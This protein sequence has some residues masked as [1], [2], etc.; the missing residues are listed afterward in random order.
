[1]RS[2]PLDNNFTLRPLTAMKKIIPVL[3]GVLLVSH[4]VRAAILLNEIHLNPPGASGLGDRNYEYIE[5][6]STLTATDKSEPTTGITLLI[7]NNDRWDYKTNEFN[8]EVATKLNMGEVTDAW[9][10]DD[11]KTGTNGLLLLGDKYA[12][13]PKGGPWAGFIDPATEVGDPP[14]MGDGN[15]RSNDG[16]TIYLVAGW[17]NPV[18][19]GGTVLEAVVDFDVDDNGVLDWDQPDPKPAGSIPRPWLTTLDRI[20]T[21]DRNTTAWPTAP[22]PPGV[23]GIAEP[24]VA[25]AAANINVYALTTPP[26]WSMGDRDPDS[27]SRNA[28]NTTASLAAAWYG[29]KFPD[30]LPGT[31]P[32]TSIAFRENRVFGLAS[33]VATPGRVNL[34]TAPPVA[35][36]RINEVNLDPSGD[37]FQ[38]VEIVNTNSPS[39]SRSLSGY[40][41][42]MVDSN[43]TASDAA[44][45]VLNRVGTILE[46]WDLSAMA[47][48]TNGLLLIADDAASS[49]T[50]FEDYVPAETGKGDPVGS[51]SNPKSSGFGGGDLGSKS[52]FTL[53]LIKGYKSNADNTFPEGRD[54]D[55]NEDG[56]LDANAFASVGNA[57]N[58]TIVDS[59]GFDMATPMPAGPGKTYA[60]V[61]LRT[62]FPVYAADDGNK[63]ADN[64][65]RKTAGGLPVA[66]N[67]AG[68]WYGGEY[69]SSAGFN[70][71]FQPPL[72]DQA[73]PVVNPTGVT[74]FGG[75]RGAATPGRANLSAAIDAAAPPI[76]AEIRI[77]EVMFDPTG[78]DITQPLKDQNRDYIELVSTNR[79]LAY[80]E[81]YWIL[82]IDNTGAN[83]G[84]VFKGAPLDGQTTGLN[85]ILLLGDNY[86]L[87][88]SVDYVRTDGRLPQS[89]ATLDPVSA[90]GGDDIP[91]G[92][93]SVLLIRGPAFD[94]ATAPNGPFKTGG[95]ITLGANLKPGGDIDP[96]NDGV[97][98][99]PTDWLA[100]GSVLVDALSTGPVNPGSGY[101][102]ISS[103]WL[104]D[105]A[106]RYP[107][108]MGAAAVQDWYYGEV[109]QAVNDNPQTAFTGNYSGTFR[110]NASPGRWNHGAAV[111]PIT[112]GSVLLNEVH[113]N[114]AGSDG[115][116][117]YIELMDRNL[118]SRS[119]NTYSLLMI[120]NVKN[121]TGTVQ[122]MWPL[123]GFMTGP[124]GLF[125]ATNGTKDT[126]PFAPVFRSQTSVSDPPGRNDLLTGFGDATIATESDNQSVMLI[127]V[128]NFNLYVGADLD[129]LA[130]ALASPGDGVF[131]FPTASWDGGN[132][133][134]SI[135]LRSWLPA[136][137]NP[138]AAAQW[139]GF[140][141]N[142]ADLSG[143]F[144][145]NPGTLF[146]HPETA[147]RFRG[148]V[149]PN[150]GA[151]WY[152]GD[153]VGGVSGKLGT[154]TTY[155]PSSPTNTTN[156]PMPL[157]FLGRATPGQPNLAPNES[158]DTDGDG[159][160]TLLEEAFGSDPFARDAVSPLPVVGTVTDAGSSYSAISYRRIKGGASSAE[161]V[162]AAEAFT[163][164]VETSTGLNTWIN[165]G[166]A[167]MQYGATTPNADG[168]TETVTFRLLA[169][170]TDP[171]GRAF[172]RLRVDRQ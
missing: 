47:T 10:L 26:A 49:Y 33:G 170:L 6:R 105:C 114:P 135:V 22:A 159:M 158:A 32:A 140:T 153:L 50:S 79:A 108:K 124:G 41:L 77:S 169:P 74:H 86:D 122:R 150:T 25:P 76:T 15:I 99:P 136:V 101:G 82:V 171:A 148:N 66:T 63:A 54:V 139:N 119:L 68:S 28:N 9:S 172:M 121:N 14:G 73:T 4:P 104:P 156:P 23:T 106:A 31:D 16:L 96:E 155:L 103:P 30:P 29:G 137:V 111:G 17:T 81:G 52:G 60:S 40:W 120:D 126:S 57:A 71:G 61:N 165:D 64:F 130:G 149:T 112:V 102:W 151:A 53:L 44:P 12:E 89:T 164:R 143:T 46:E 87:P 69:P 72:T 109:D 127:L 5:L 91:N 38:D 42:V 36:F 13:L 152:A 129:E 34:S 98:L 146:Y 162:Y 167:I 51:T 118:T 27:F 45:G 128:K 11:M 58:V 3:T 67:A 2:L 133:H 39:G 160:V 43:V 92:G 113:F 35:D 37:R 131:D 75:F 144:F 93:A 84:V 117:E 88:G 80:L 62:V 85:G 59:I 168:F 65:S 8:V 132:V 107:D 20:G 70:L 18:P 115:N 90:F 56:I 100:P 97:L 154:D 166:S 142:L 147:S 123:D 83:K 21:R 161:K 95:P 163:Y 141:Y 94:P 24:Y 19:N 138:P 145:P 110:G 116:F 55:A 48:G 125:V 134:D 1:M 78:G 7:I 157:G